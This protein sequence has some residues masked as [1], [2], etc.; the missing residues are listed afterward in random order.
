MQRTRIEN[1]MN[2][3]QKT[4]V[5]IPS[6]VIGL[7]L[8]FSQ[9]QVYATN[10]LSVCCAWNTKVVDGLSYTISGGGSSAQ[11]AVQ[12]AIDD[13]NTAPTG[14][15]LTPFTSTSGKPDIDI[16]FKLGGGTIAGQALRQFDANGF[17]KSVKLTI[18]GKA[19]GSPNDANIITQITKHEL[20][21]ALG[22][23]HANFD[24]DLMSTTVQGGSNT[25]STCDING[26]KEA[27]HWFIVDLDTTPH[28]RH[29][30]SIAC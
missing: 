15:T 17:I 5:I 6:L 29:V 23:G 14:I 3:L 18:S 25:I 30:S 12:S 24:G 10:S 7:A 1:R 11:A 28:Q 26:V 8:I 4:S 27:N 19:F 16:K 20:G 22:L 13:W 21:H 2:K 9:Q